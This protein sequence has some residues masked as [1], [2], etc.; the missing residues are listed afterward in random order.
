MG[1][2]WAA[3]SPFLHFTDHHAELG[4]LVTEGRRSEFKGFAAFSSPDA[5]ARIPDPQDEGTF[6]RSQLEIKQFLT[7]AGLRLRRRFPKLFLE[8]EYLPLEAEG[9]RASH[10]VALARRWR[11][12][13]LVAI[14]S[15]LCHELGGANRRPPLG[16]RAWRDSRVWLPANDRG[17]KLLDVFTGVAVTTSREDGRHGLYLA[18]ALAALPVALLIRPSTASV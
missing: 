9:T 16:A 18:D 6:L 17:G 8:G 12:D 1:Q 13:L 10:V 11:D 14:V 15:R 4:R 2:E 5:R 3:T 7:A